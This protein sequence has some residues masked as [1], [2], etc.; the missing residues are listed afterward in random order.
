MLVSVLAFSVVKVFDVAELSAFWI[1]TEDFG[2]SSTL[3]ASPG[4]ET[5]WLGVIFKD[6]VDGGRGA[7]DCSSRSIGSRGCCA[8]CGANLWPGTKEKAVGL[9]LLMVGDKRASDLRVNSCHRSDLSPLDP[10]SI[11]VPDQYLAILKASYDYTPQSDDE[12]AIKLDQRLLLVERVD[13]E[14]VVLFS[15]WNLLG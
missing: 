8:C 15:L 13:E 7:S 3:F 1:F 5:G 2:P 14:F 6:I 4:A 10:M 9:S 11:Q 12:I